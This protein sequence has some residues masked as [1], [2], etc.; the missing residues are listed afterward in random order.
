VP[1]PCTELLA[2][3]CT[4][5]A[6]WLRYATPVRHLASICLKGRALALLPPALSFLPCSLLFV[7][8]RV[9]HGR[10]AEL[11]ATTARFFVLAANHRIAKYGKASTAARPRPSFTAS[12]QAPEL[13]RRRAVATAAACARGRSASGHVP[14]IR[15]HQRVRVGPHVLSRPFS[16]TGEPPPAGV[17]DSVS[18][19][20][21]LPR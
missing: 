10:P 8:G 17:G 6:A 13:R 14:A 5:R 7:R 15:D 11:V 3:C 16:A 9:H 2:A 19:S 1:T 21:V 4:A 18:A 12:R 20:S